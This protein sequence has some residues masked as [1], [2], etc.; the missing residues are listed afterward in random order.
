MDSNWENFVA[1]KALER[2]VSPDLISDHQHEV[3]INV[4]NLNFINSLL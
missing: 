3:F 2:F 4:K 1:V